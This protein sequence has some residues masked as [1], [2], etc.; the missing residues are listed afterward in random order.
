VN[1]L[2]STDVIDRLTG[3]AHYSGVRIEIEPV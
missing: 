2:T 1:F 3:M